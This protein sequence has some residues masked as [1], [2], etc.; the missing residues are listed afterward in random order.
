MFAVRVIDEESEH[1]SNLMVGS[2]LTSA[3][4]DKIE[5]TLAN[6]EGARKCM[7]LSCGTKKTDR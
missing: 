1:L 7:E 5:E 4:I 2:F 6:R 3:Y